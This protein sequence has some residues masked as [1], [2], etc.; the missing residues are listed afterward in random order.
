MIT[1][2]PHALDA[3]S[4]FLV[5]QG[6]S[7]AIRIQLQSTGCC[8]A[9]LGLMIDAPMDTDLKENINGVTFVVSPEVNKITGDINI[10][11]SMDDSA[12]GFVVTSEHPVS[13]WAGFGA[14]T[15]KY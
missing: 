5:Q 2:T 9:S 15:I 14:C 8:D 13:E 3:I 10:A 12:A 4:L 6:I 7:G 1:V 11:R